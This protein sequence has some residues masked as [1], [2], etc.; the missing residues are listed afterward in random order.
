[1]YHDLRVNAR[2]TACPFS[3]NGWL[4]VVLGIHQ[5]HA[6]YPFEQATCLVP[7]TPGP[8]PSGT[9]IDFP[10]RK[11]KHD[12]AIARF[13]FYQNV[14]QAIVKHITI[15]VGE[16]IVNT[17]VNATSS[18]P[19]PHELLEYLVRDYVRST[20]KAQDVEAARMKMMAKIAITDAWAD[21]VQQIERGRDALVRIEGPQQIRRIFLFR[22]QIH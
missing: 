9:P 15:A 11:A 2:N 12:E 21:Y 22:S 13:E 8:L 18:I 16:D 3:V 20:Y 14:K 4:W 10:E 1:L 7:P 17:Y 19:P 6:E 5:Y